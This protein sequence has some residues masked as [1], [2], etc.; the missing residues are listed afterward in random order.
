MIYTCAIKSPLG[1][2]IAAAEDGAVTGLWFE[3]QTYYPV[4]AGWIRK[5]DY[6]PFEALRDWVDRYFAGEVPALPK[7]RSHKT[8]A[9]E[10]RCFPVSAGKNLL[11]NPRGTVFQEAV[12]EI[13]LAIPYGES[14]TYGAIAK[15]I[16]AARGV[17]MMA[18]QAVGGA[19][20]HNA[21]SLLIPCHRVLGAGR[22]LTGY[23]GGLDRNTALLRLEGQDL[24]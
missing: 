3:R 23:G 16:S 1:K 8:A 20:G 22:K 18:A 12:W 24:P 21:I 6:P 10:G 5:P 14:S 7:A 9:P 19:V 17:P 4:T 11:L 13:L 2:M 15:Q